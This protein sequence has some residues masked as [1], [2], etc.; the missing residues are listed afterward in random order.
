MLLQILSFRIKRRGYI[1]GVV[2]NDGLGNRIAGIPGTFLLSL[3]SY[4]YFHC[5]LLIYIFS[6]RK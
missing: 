6:A 1:F 5:I 4:R 3:L 2:S